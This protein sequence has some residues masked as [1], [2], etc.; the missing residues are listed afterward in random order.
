MTQATGSQSFYDAFVEIRPAAMG[1]WIDISGHG[2]SISEGG[3]D[4]QTGEAYTHD[5]DTAIIGFGKREPKEITVRAVYTE[6]ASDPYKYVLDAYHDHTTLQVRWSPLGGDLNEKRY[7]TD[8][9]YSIVTSCPDP[10]GEAGSGDPI[11]FEFVV[12]TSE[13]FQDTE[14][15]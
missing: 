15:T 7:T 4:R 12:K 5:G 11:M 3:G 1:I 9:T 2:S 14:S 10:T 8:P 13:T 6:G